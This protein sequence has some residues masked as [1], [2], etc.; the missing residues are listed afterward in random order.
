MMIFVTTATTTMIA[1]TDRITLFQLLLH[2]IP[3]LHLTATSIARVPTWDTAV[4]QHSS[5]IAI[6]AAMITM[7]LLL[8][9]QLFLS[10]ATDDLALLQQIIL[11]LQ[12]L[13]CDFMYSALPKDSRPCT[14]LCVCVLYSSVP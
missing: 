3:T 5:S 11:L 14:L 2:S 1:I 4:L 10:Q 7:G 13:W 12:Q 6:I 8:Q 9:L